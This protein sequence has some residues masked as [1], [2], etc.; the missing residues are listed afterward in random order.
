[1][2][3]QF[4]KNGTKHAKSGII[5]RVPAALEDLTIFAGVAEQS[6]FVRASRKLGIPTSTVSR[7]VARLEAELG[8]QLLRRTSRK[9]TLTDEGRQLHLRA[10]PHLEGIEEAL[11]STSDRHPEPSGVVRVTAPAYTGATRVAAALSA[12]ALAHPKI[13]IELDA[14]NVL[15]DLV[16]DGY[17]FG[18]RVGPLHNR[19]FVTRRLWSGSFGLFASRAFIQSALRGRTAITRAALEKQPCIALRPAPVWRFSD[20]KG[21]ATALTPHV[22][23]AVNDPRAMIEVAR[24]GLGIVLAPTEAVAASPAGLVRLRADF[25]EP[26]PLDLYLLYPTRR[27]QPER[28]RLVI[29]WLIR[30]GGSR[31]DDGR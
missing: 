8:V 29:D 12:C 27:L 11:A 17:D 16:Q 15:R 20:A 22:R 9:V 6:S 28:V 18:V 7:A 14:S 4:T 24:Q 5:R 31:A 23:F 2:T 19:D 10:A 3:G 13:R 25:G 30:A 26:E 1:M 21:Q